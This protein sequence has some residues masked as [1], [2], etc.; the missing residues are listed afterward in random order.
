[1]VV[2]TRADEGGLVAVALRDVE[3]E[4]VSIEAQRPVDVGDFQVHVADVHPGIDRVR[5]G[6][7]LTDG[8]A[9]APP[10][11][12]GYG[13]QGQEPFNAAKPRAASAASSAFMRPDMSTSLPQSSLGRSGEGNTGRHLLS[14]TTSDGFDGG[15]VSREDAARDDGP[16]ADW[17]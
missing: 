8:G 16:T 17:T 13:P 4:H 5:H 1:M 15:R 2:A 3:A 12:T 6:G 11:H 9:E 7:K 10:S 14:T